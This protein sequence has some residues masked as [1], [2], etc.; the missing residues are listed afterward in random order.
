MECLKDALA[1]TPSVAAKLKAEDAEKTILEAVGS[2][3]QERERFNRKKIK[4]FVGNLSFRVDSD[5]LFRYCIIMF[6]L[7]M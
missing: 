3:P 5:A 4:L 7:I 2:L 6:L 1:P